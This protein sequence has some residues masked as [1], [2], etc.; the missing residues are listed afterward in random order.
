[1][2]ILSLRLKNLNS[3]KGEWRIDFTTAPFAGNGLFAITGPTGAGKT[4]ILDAICLALY[5][6]T[7]RIAGVSQG[8]NEVMTRHTAECLAEVEFEVRGARYRSFWSQRRAHGKPDGALQQVQVELVAHVR[9]EGGG[10]ILTTR[11]QDKLRQ[12]EVLTGLNFERFTRSMLLAQGGFAAF[13]EASAGKRAELLEELTGTD[14]YGQ[15]SQRVFESARDART[16]LEQMRARAGGVE[17][18]D[19]ATRATLVDEAGRLALHARALQAQRQAAARERQWLADKDRAQM[20]RD[21]AVRHREQAQAEWDAGAEDSLRLAASEPAARLQ[22]VHAA[23]QAARHDALAV[24]RQ[25]D[26]AQARHGQAVD[27]CARALRQVQRES[28]RLARLRENEWQDVV[29]A[30]ET[31]SQELAAV[32]QHAQLGEWLSGWREQFGARAHRLQA[33]AETRARQ[34]KQGSECQA[35]EAQRAGYEQACQHAAAALNQAQQAAV[36]V[37]QAHERLTL[38][39]EESAWRDAPLQLLERS[40]AWERLGQSLSAWQQA[41]SRQAQWLAAQTERQRQ[42]ADE[43]QAVQ[44]LRDRYAS[45]HRQVQD[46][47]KLLAQEQRIQAL[48]AHRSHLQPG[49]AC[50]LC[51]STTHPAIEAY[52]ALDVSATQ[53]A[54]EMLCAQRDEVTEQGQARRSRLAALQ[55]QSDQVAQQ[56]AEGEQALAQWLAQW[57]ACCAASD[58]PVDVVDAQVIADAQARHAAA[59]EAAQQQWVE[60]AQ[61]RTRL[62]E[63]LSALQQAEQAERAALQQRALS[64]KDLQAARERADELAR[65]LQQQQSQHAEAEAALADQLRTL[66]YTL[67]SD[68]ADWLQQRAQEHRA[69]QSAQARLQALAASESALKQVADMAGDAAQRWAAVGAPGTRAEVDALLREDPESGS[70]DLVQAVEQAEA[71]WRAAENELATLQGMLES[72]QRRHAEVQEAQVRAEQDW[73]QALSLSP[74]ADET[75][76]R[77]AGMGEPEREALRAQLAQRQQALA[78]ANALQAAAEAALAEL[79]SLPLTERSSEDLAAL[80]AQWEAELTLAQQQQGAIASR[81]QD[82]AQRRDGLQALLAQIQAQE[83]DH[84]LWQHLNGLIGSADGA[85]YRKFAQGLTLDHLVHL[86]N[87]QLGR[88]HGRYRLGRRSAGELELEVIDTWQADVARDTRTLSGGESFLVS[89]ALALALSDLVSHKASIDSLFLD[90]GFGTLDGET[91][92]TALDALDTLNASGKTIG[93]ISHVEALKERIPVQIRVHKG[94]GLGYSAL[95]RRFS[96]G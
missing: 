20:R 86:A 67:P 14:I 45:L 27:R 22:P 46:Q 80:M 16:V 30:R 55:A 10:E 62:D 3:L 26:D 47:E 6:Q 33:M 7:P 60:I 71:L 59:L 54:L 89:L 17:L 76:F 72:L 8:G 65:H 18:L 83:A 41:R 73:V 75:A 32:P 52:E 19:E 24:V 51:G 29:Q 61:A 66:G 48:E 57:Q 77:A 37:R 69:W 92:E 39:R 5:H 64:D 74:F 81:L 96:V 85:K 2:R 36:A 88:L 9:G 70:E 1:M 53:S 63:T 84:D 79:Q 12:T 78:E 43:A 68:G 15:I 93:I 38:G 87:R 42:E 4:T 28:Q 56:I 82:D 90:E 25:R 49:E 50:P 13:L 21:E 94:V 35:L 34:E 11:V 23:W 95:E 31:L 44:S 58:W 40:H 91:L